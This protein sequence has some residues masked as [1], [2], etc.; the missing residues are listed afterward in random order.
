MLNV[1]A[2]TR[3]SACAQDPSSLERQERICVEIVRKHLDTDVLNLFSDF[4]VAGDTAQPGLQSLLEA[5]LA[6]TVDVIVVASFD[7]LLRGGKDAELVCKLLHETNVR[8][9]TQDGECQITSINVPA[10]AAS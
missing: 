7:R 1:A 8:I 10:R 5:A 6:G 4:S 3:S 9:F 2:Y